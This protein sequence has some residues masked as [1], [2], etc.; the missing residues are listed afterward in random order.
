MA[1]PV[2]KAGKIRILNQFGIAMPEFG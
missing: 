2:I 1:I